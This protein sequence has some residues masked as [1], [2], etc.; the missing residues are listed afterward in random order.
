[1]PVAVN[2]QQRLRDRP[3]NKVGTNEI[4]ME[5]SG[6]NVT[7]GWLELVVNGQWENVG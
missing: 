2:D 4:A 1:M 5:S 6:V 7:A 3:P